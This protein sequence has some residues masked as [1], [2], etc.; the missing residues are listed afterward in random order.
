V[1]VIVIALFF[2]GYGIALTYP[3]AVLNNILFSQPPQAVR[4]TMAFVI[5]CAGFIPL[6]SLQ[7]FCSF[8]KTF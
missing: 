1:V 4:F 2:I 6:L 5:M 7:Y 8:N 3:T